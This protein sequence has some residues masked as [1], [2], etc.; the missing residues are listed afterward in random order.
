MKLVAVWFFSSTSLKIPLENNL[1]GEYPLENTP[2][3]ITTENTPVEN[4][5][6]QI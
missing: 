4:K 6:F 2:W 1:H 3:K 5:V